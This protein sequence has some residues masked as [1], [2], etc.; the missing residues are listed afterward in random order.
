MIV[1]CFNAMPTDKQIEEPT[2]NNRLSSNE[3]NQRINYKL[4]NSELLLS[5]LQPNMVIQQ[6]PREDPFEHRNDAEEES[7]KTK[8][9]S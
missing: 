2:K 1:V 4:H 5:V 9:A 8:G 3:E 7:G 6:M